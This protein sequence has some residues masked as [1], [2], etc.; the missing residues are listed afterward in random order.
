VGNHDDPISLIIE[1]TSLDEKPVYDALSYVWGPQIPSYT[2]ECNGGCLAIGGSLRDALLAFRKS[3]APLTLW[4]DRIAIN[5]DDVAE[6][7]QQVNLMA[8]IYRSASLAVIWLGPADSS[9]E[10]AFG[11]INDLTIQMLEFWKTQK[12]RNY[13]EARTADHP[14]QQPPLEAPVWSAVR[15]LLQR[16]WFS[17]VWTF[18]EIV[19]AQKAVLHCGANMMTWQRLEAFLV[20]LRTWSEGPN[21]EDSRLKGDEKSLLEIVKARSI[22]HRPEAHKPEDSQVFLGLF[23]LLESLRIRQATDPR[24]KVFA[25][26]N[27]ANDAKDSNLKPD[28][29]KSPTEVYALTAK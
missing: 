14:L 4:I 16:P 9:S 10:S 11:F 15:S 6:R 7:T 20:C 12:S 17:R 22:L 24:D 18:Q 19:L 28:Y 23:P 5:Q 8:D 27:V 25:L 3:D 29:T 21:A 1:R 26:L 13:A 2:V